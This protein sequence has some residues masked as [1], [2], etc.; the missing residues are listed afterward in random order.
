M[1][2]RNLLVDGGLVQQEARRLELGLRVVTSVCR[3]RRVR[4]HEREESSPA[5]LL[6]LMLAVV[7][8]LVTKYNVK[9]FFVTGVDQAVEDELVEIDDV[10]DVDVS[11]AE[12]VEDSLC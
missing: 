7:R 11:R 12:L 1:E 9:C 2:V 5:I 10:L 6:H 4:L 8:P 3:D